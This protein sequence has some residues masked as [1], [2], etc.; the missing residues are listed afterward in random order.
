MPESLYFWLSLKFFYAHVETFLL[1]AVEDKVLLSDILFLDLIGSVN[2][3]F[4]I[5][6]EPIP[7]FSA[8]I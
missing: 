5:L 8:N 1:V 7:Y 3:S 2:N 6:T 4:N